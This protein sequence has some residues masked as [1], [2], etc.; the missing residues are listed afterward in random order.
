MIGL[1]L[2]DGNL[3]TFSKNGNTWRLRILQGGENHFDYIQHL[4]LLFDN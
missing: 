2:G 3:Q 1:L 4:R